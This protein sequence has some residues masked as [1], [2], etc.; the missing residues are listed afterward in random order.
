MRL[1]IALTALLLAVTAVFV[2][3]QDTDLNPASTCTV[4]EETAFHDA[5]TA[6]LDAPAAPD[7][8]QQLSALEAVIVTQRWQCN[9]MK[10]KG[11]AG[12]GK[13]SVVIGPVH[14]PDGTYRVTLTT[15]E[16]ITVES[17]ISY[18]DC[19]MYISA[20]DGEASN[21]TEQIFTAGEECELVLEVGAYS[22]WTLQF[23]LLK[24]GK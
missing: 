12:P 5:L 21:G 8:L 19:S 16:F 10:L 24:A 22:D 20:Q 7:F 3:A 14:I 23:A 9:G 13:T 17:D 6:L 1:K 4:D 15:N 2:L 11:E 18:G